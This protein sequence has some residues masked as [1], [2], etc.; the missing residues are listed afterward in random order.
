VEEKT[1]GTCRHWH[2]R[3]I[4]PNN[5]GAERQGDCRE[6]PPAL[7]TIPA[8][9]SVQ[10]VAVYPALPSAFPACSRHCERSEV[11]RG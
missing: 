1:C 8:P 3:P 4:D 6:G 2:Q 7:L 5:L 11:V 10:G 9:R